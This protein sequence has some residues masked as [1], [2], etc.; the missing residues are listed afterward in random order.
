[1]HAVQLEEARWH[2][3]YTAIRERAP[4]PRRA[5]ERRVNALVTELDEERL[6]SLMRWQRWANLDSGVADLEA[7]LSQAAV[8]DGHAIPADVVTMNSL[9][10]C[11]D[12]QTG[13]WTRFR[14]VYPRDVCDQGH[15]SILLPLGAA[16]L[17]AK[18]GSVVEEKKGERTRRLRIRSVPY[19]PER[20]GHFHL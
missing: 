7:R 16:L 18:V 1:M 4:R 11:E 17:G 12:E 6:A 5:P 19:Q 10:L 20:S 13:A 8:V 3:G 15:V 14:L 2:D 9:V